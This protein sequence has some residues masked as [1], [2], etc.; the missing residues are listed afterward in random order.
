MA[1]RGDSAEAVLIGIGPIHHSLLIEWPFIA[2]LQLLL[3]P[4]VMV[5]TWERLG[6]SSMI[7]L[8]A[9]DLKKFKK[10]YCTS[11]CSLSL[12]FELISYRE[13]PR[14]RG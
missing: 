8:E 2:L 13:H 14:V 9:L 1:V 10:L 11:K 7:F 5:G 12:T 3:A 6:I 4:A